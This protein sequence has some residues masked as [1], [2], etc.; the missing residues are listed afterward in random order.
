[1]KFEIRYLMG[2]KVKEDIFDIPARYSQSSKKI[3]N[4]AIDFL[5]KTLRKKH[6]LLR[7]KSVDPQVEET[8]LT[9]G[10]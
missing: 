3:L 1:M 4:T 9:A 5:N 6:I 8:Q 7:V 2:G 10:R